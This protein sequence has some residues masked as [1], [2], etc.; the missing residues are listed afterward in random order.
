MITK[1]NFVVGILMDER[2]RLF[3]KNNYETMEISKKIFCLN[4]LNNFEVY[5]D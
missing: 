4:E 2:K 5:Q 1:H 3:W